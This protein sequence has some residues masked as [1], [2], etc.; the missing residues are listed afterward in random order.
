[1]YLG[2]QLIYSVYVVSAISRPPPE[3]LTLFSEHADIGQPKYS[4]SNMN[5]AVKVYTLEEY[6]LDHFRYSC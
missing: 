5:E 2:S 6:S 3:F 4:S 1:M